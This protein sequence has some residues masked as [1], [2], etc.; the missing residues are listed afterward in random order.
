MQLPEPLPTTREG[1]QDS[2][3]DGTNCYYIVTHGGFAQ[4][5]GVSLYAMGLGFFSFFPQSHWVYSTYLFSLS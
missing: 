1:V 3:R 4:W 2:L 5:Q